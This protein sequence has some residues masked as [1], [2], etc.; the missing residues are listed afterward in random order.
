VVSPEGYWNFVDYV[1]AHASEMGGAEHS[2]AKAT[3][4][5]DKLAADEGA[6]Q[7]V[8][9]AELDACIKKQDDTKVKASVADAVKLGVDSTPALFING[10]KVEGAIPLE[11]IYRIID[12]A[13]TAAGQTPPPPVPI[14]AAAPAA[15]PG[16]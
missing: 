14:P 12:G 3:A 11:Y 5:L 15:K 13:L 16:N 1:H 4:D 7:K 8:N 2:V 10:E 6:R 9:A